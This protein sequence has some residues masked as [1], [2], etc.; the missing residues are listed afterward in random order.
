MARMILDGLEERKLYAGPPLWAYTLLQVFI[1]ITGVGL[2][3][4]WFGASNAAGMSGVSAVLSGFGWLYYLVRQTHWRRQINYATWMF[5][6]FICAL[7]AAAFQPKPELPPVLHFVLAGS[8]A[9]AAL[10]RMHQIVGNWP[11][12]WQTR[13]TKLDE[14]C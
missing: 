1:A 14:R 4:W 11:N 7:I 5:T 12:G 3:W 6:W 10:W 2:V 13:L 9:I 8:L